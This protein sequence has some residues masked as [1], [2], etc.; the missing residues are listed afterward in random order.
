[1][2]LVVLLVIDRLVGLRVDATTESEGLDLV[3][4]GEVIA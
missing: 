3:E 2:T 1:M 4:H